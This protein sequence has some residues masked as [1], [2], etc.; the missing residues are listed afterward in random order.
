MSSVTQR[1]REIKQPRGGYIKPSQLEEKI[2]YDGET[3]FEEENL[4]ASIVGMAVDYLTRLSMGADVD[5][6]FSISLQGAMAAASS[7][8]S[9]A[10]QMAD[11]FL[12]NIRKGTDDNSVKLVKISGQIKELI[13]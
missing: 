8:M 10:M 6:A 12:S 7:G 2:L 4:H 11:E 3:L 1:I 13:F 5:D 9:N